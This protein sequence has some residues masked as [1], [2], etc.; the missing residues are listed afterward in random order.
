MTQMSSVLFIE[1]SVRSRI[2]LIDIWKSSKGGKVIELSVV[3][4]SL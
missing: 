1:N 4:N 2:I 3:Y